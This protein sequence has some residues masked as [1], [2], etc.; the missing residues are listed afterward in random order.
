MSLVDENILNI[1]TT[2]KQLENQKIIEINNL[3]YKKYYVFSPSVNSFWSINNISYDLNNNKVEAVFVKESGSI[4]H[5]TGFFNRT[6]PLGYDYGNKNGYVEYQNFGR[7]NTK[8]LTDEEI[9]RSKPSQLTEAENSLI[10]HIGN[11]TILKYDQNLTDGIMITNPCYSDDNF[12]I[13]NSFLFK[14]TVINSPLFF[15]Y[16]NR[17]LIFYLKSSV[18]NFVKSIL[19]FEYDQMFNPMKNRLGSLYNASTGEFVSR[20]SYKYN[21]MT[22]AYFSDLLSINSYA[23]A[24]MP[25]SYFRIL[26]VL[27]N[28][29]TFADL[30]NMTEMK[31]IFNIYMS[32]YK[33]TDNTINLI[34]NKYYLTKEHFQYKSMY[35]NNSYLYVRPESDIIFSR[36]STIMNMLLPSFSA[37]QE[38]MKLRTMCDGSI[39]NV[40]IKQVGPL[41]NL[42]KNLPNLTAVFD[43]NNANGATSTPGNFQFIAR[44]SDNS[45]FTPEEFVDMYNDPIKFKFIISQYDGT[46]FIEIPYFNFPVIS[47]SIITSLPF[48]P[49]SELRIKKINDDKFV[50][51]IMQISSTISTS[52]SFQNFEDLIT[53]TYTIKELSTAEFVPGV[54]ASTYYF[55]FPRNILELFLTS[56][57]FR[58]VDIS[59]AVDAVSNQIA[60]MFISDTEMIFYGLTAGRK[61]QTMFSYNN[62]QA[63]IENLEV[64]MISY[65]GVQNMEVKNIYTVNYNDYTLIP[66]NNSVFYVIQIENFTRSNNDISGILTVAEPTNFLTGTS[67]LI[68]ADTNLVI[69]SYP[70]TY[71]KEEL[72]IVRYTLNGDLIREI[73]WYSRVLENDVY[74]YH[75]R[76]SSTGAATIIKPSIIKYN[77]NFTNQTVPYLLSSKPIKYLTFEDGWYSGIDAINYFVDELKTLTELTTNPAKITFNQFTSKISITNPTDENIILF[78]TIPE[79][80]F[81]ESSSSI[82]GSPD[83]SFIIQRNSTTTMPLP[84][85][86]YFNGR[87]SQIKINLLNFSN[88]GFINESLTLIKMIAKDKKGTLTQNQVVNFIKM[89]PP[90]IVLSNLS[91][92]IVDNKNQLVNFNETI[93]LEFLIRCVND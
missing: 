84:M 93:D 68:T 65:R 61:F 90:N 11:Q 48:K 21:D 8:I 92:Q 9:N 30:L 47:D 24:V 20:T 23:Y 42:H 83:Q 85:D 67:I 70:E 5:T 86:L 28:D 7:K 6:L 58:M 46:G 79:N 34:R 52:N 27:K 53:R 78:F 17:F 71:S 3:K 14:G 32:P 12:G 57:P 33:F 54:T 37:N 2:F 77:T 50:V 87:F 38:L 13:P 45:K 43:N 31:N 89:L 75:F 22:D 16:S 88:F 82:Y 44:R 19:F 80:A 29:I 72:K 74:N 39:Q 15:N 25:Q 55:K 66:F 73:T 1:Q 36:F 4:D 35:L 64:R 69:L 51:K 91:F 56:N 81:Q 10:N 18:S 76:T 60:P 49:P 59:T 62:N 41:F 40:G 63:E 26:I